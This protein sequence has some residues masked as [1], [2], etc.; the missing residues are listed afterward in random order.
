M[1]IRN[2][3]SVCSEDAK[4]WRIACNMSSGSYSGFAMHEAVQRYLNELM[5][6]PKLTSSWKVEQYVSPSVI[7]QLRGLPKSSVVVRNVFFH[8]NT[9]GGRNGPMVSEF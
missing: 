5:I 4:A 6:A 9:E 8:C 1:T 7:G 2:G 3:A